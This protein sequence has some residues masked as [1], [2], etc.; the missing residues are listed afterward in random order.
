MLGIDRN[1]R[2]FIQHH[3]F[4]S[5]DKIARHAAYHEPRVCSTSDNEN[6]FIPSIYLTFLSFKSMIKRIQHSECWW[7]WIVATIGKPLPFAIC[8]E[9][10]YENIVCL[11]LHSLRETKTFFE[12]RTF[13]ASTLMSRFIHTISLINPIVG[14]VYIYGRKRKT[15]S[16]SNHNRSRVKG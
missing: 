11:C 8:V 13:H 6:R 15:A 2:N 7:A 3:K 1:H 14:N 12:Q 5:S 10:K 4:I 16:H 9:S